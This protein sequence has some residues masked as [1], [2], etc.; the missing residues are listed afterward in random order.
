MRQNVTLI[1]NCNIF[2]NCI[3]II[4]LEKISLANV[5]KEAK[6]PKH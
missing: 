1:G 4:K 3:K 6:S 5:W 2:F